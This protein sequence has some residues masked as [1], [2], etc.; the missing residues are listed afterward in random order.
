MN[1]KNNF[2]NK[3]L[4]MSFIFVQLFLL[5]IKANCQEINGF[6]INSKQ[7]NFDILLPKS[8]IPWLKTVSAT[9]VCNG[10]EYNTTVLKS[11]GITLK[12]SNCTFGKGETAVWRF[13]HPQDQLA[14]RLELSNYN[15]SDWLSV[16]GWVENRSGKKITMNEIRLLDSKNGFLLAGDPNKW[17][18][19]SGSTDNLVWTGEVLKQPDNQIKSRQIM[20]LWNSASELMDDAAI[21]RRVR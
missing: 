12:T 21:L 16:D 17:R 10:K 14:F 15:T 19:L 8:T 13:S 6:S 3:L 11:E 20:G 7:N 1:W 18:V 9:F 2:F 5:G 4:L